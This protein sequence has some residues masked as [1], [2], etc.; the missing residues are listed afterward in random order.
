LR[1]AWPTGSFAA[2][3]R[4]QVGLGIVPR[5]GLASAQHLSPALFGD[6]MERFVE[7]RLLDGL[8]DGLEDERMRRLAL[9]LG[10]GGNAGL[11][12]VFEAD[13]SGG[14][15][16]TCQLQGLHCSTHVL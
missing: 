1:A 8:G 12:I 16:L 2:S 9:A 4:L 14:H 11:Q 10:R 7:L 15:C 13:R 6:A 3:S 5:H